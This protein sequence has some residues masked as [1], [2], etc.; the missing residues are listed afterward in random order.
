MAQR[1]RNVAIACAF[2]C[3]AVVAW[4]LSNASSR[5]G[6]DASEP[7]MHGVATASADA[8]S[9]ANIGNDS[10]RIDAP[11]V[12]DVATTSADGAASEEHR[13]HFRVHVVDASD[14]GVQ[15]VTIWLG[16][17]DPWHV[18]QMETT[19]QDGR[20]K[21]SVPRRIGPIDGIGIVASLAGVTA[22]GSLEGCKETDEIELKL[23]AMGWFSLT[24]DGPLGN[25]GAQLVEW[26]G[27]ETFGHTTT[28][29]FDEPTERVAVGLGSSYSVTVWSGGERDVRAGVVGPK[30]PDEV[31]PLSF[32]FRRCAVKFAFAPDASHGDAAAPLDDESR[33]AVHLLEG[34]R[35][36]RCDYSHASDGTWTALVPRSASARLVITSGA[37]S[38]ETEPM[39]FGES[40]DLG[41]VAL[42]PMK[43][44]GVVEARMPDGTIAPGRQWPSAFVH[45]DG[46]RLSATMLRT[47]SFVVLTPTGEGT[48]MRS[49]RLFAAVEVVAKAD[50][51]YP[52]PAV[53]T[54]TG[55]SRAQVTML[56]GAEVE[57]LAVDPV[58][59]RSMALVHRAT[60]ERARSKASELEEGRPRWWFV[61][62]RPGDYDVRMDGMSSSPSSVHVPAGSTQRV[63]VVL[64]QK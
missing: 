37:T 21:I 55:A 63:M 16:T 53:A 31:V 47:G 25:V 4:T 18:W 44:F 33:V 11:G 35:S 38:Y 42:Q 7:Q 56:P 23:P 5:V 50:G 24:V 20:A 26:D 2:V 19:D 60:G 54:L 57:I 22:T 14:R 40:V 43:D 48:R 12:D 45:P 10:Q 27:H 46:T 52:E 61:G 32:D 64:T 34:K 13:Y 36:V 30:S 58:P 49:L 9:Q 51:H 17:L 8:A 3:I 29:L 1:L 41:R 6:L 15:H 39:S 62:L 28:F 59:L